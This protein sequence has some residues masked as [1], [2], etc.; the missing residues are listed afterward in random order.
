MEYAVNWTDVFQDELLSIYQYIFFN[1]K[2][3]L[4]AQNN[5]TTI[6]SKVSSLSFFPERYQ[7][8]YNSKYFNIRKLRINKFICI[9]QVDNF[10]KQVYILHIFHG[11]QNYNIFNI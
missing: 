3:P 9:Y 2:E 8:I 5:L 10:T 7:K 6:I 1:L 11:R 4:T